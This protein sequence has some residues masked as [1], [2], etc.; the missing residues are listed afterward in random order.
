[1]TSGDESLDGSRQMILNF[2]LLT[3]V[4]LTLVRYALL[5]EAVQPPTAQSRSSILGERNG[6][7]RYRSEVEVRVEVGG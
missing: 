4:F 6:R 7:E 1:M 5:P 3:G 2:F